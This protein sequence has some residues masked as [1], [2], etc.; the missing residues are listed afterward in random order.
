MRPSPESHHSER[1]LETI[2][3]LGHNLE[4]TMLAEG[5]ET[6]EQLDRLIEL[7]C[8]LGQGF[9]FSPAVPIDEATAMV[10]RTF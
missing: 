3:S 5:I 4:M 8:E 7:G 1:L 9:I 2:V 6:T 10:D